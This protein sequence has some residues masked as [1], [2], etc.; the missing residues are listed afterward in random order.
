MG[1]IEPV[2]LSDLAQPGFIPAEE[3]ALDLSLANDGQIRL[4]GNVTQS[5][6]TNF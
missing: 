4:L 3:M 2:G 6:N 1:I 5:D